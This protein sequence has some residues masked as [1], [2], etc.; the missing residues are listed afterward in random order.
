MKWEEGQQPDSDISR[1]STDAGTNGSAELTQLLEENQ[2]RALVTCRADNLQGLGKSLRLFHVG[3][4]TCSRRIMCVPSL[5][6]ILQ[7][8]SIHFGDFVFK[9]APREEVPPTFLYLWNHM[10]QCK[11]GCWLDSK[12]PR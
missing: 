6:S 9:S 2:V 11:V 5:V 12:L 4:G 8:L 3:Y 1:L 7:T 10:E